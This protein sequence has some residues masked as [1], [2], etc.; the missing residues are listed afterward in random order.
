MIFWLELQPVPVIVIVGYM[1]CFA[2][3]A[4][5]FIVGCLL[6]RTRFADD[7]SFITPSL[8]TPLV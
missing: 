3:A 7:L 6:S 2:M 1:L 4:A 5:T 8:L